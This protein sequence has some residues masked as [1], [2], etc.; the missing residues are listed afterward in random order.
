MIQNIPQCFFFFCTNRQFYLENNYSSTDF[1]CGTLV[2]LVRT[3][4]L[5]NNHS[6]ANFDVVLAP[7]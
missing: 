1:G 5:S 2:F 6:I 4:F 3:A 7:G